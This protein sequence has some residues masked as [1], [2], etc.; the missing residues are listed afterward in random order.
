MTYSYTQVSQYLSCPRRYRYRYLD[1]WVEKETSAG[2]IFGRAF[3]NTLAALFRH[4]DP[5]QALFDH[6][7]IYRNLALEYSRGETWD[8]MLESGIHLLERFVQDDRVRIP[9]PRRNLQIK[10]SRQLLGGN[11]FVGYVDAI[12]HLDG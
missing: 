6:W 10:F 12:G 11:H 4:E 7:S 8:T 9:N 2:M 3:E 5:G 1:G